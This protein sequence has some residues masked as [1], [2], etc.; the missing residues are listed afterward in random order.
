MPLQTAGATAGWVGEGAPKPVSKLAF[1]TTSLGMSKIA[2]IVALTEELVRTSNPSA[3]ATC[4]QDLIDTISQFMDE[5][6]INPAITAVTNV[7]PASV[8]NGAQ[9]YASSGSTVDQ[10]TADVAKMLTFFATNR[11]RMRA[12]VWVMNPRTAIALSMKRNTDGSFAFPGISATGGTFFGYKVVTSQSV[13][14]TGSP[15][16]TYMTL[17]DA[18]EILMADDGGVTLDVSREASLQMNDAPSAGA[19]QMVSL[20]Q[21]NLIGLRAERYIN[22]RRRRPQAVVTLTGLTY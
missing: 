1:D 10:I 5:Q 3:E 22:Y 12:P 18:S 4:R 8:T 14:I 6:F 19:Q 20:W 21:N 7:S 2:V 16:T 9:S 13:G 11:V 17:M 15:G